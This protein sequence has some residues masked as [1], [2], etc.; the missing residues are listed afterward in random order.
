MVKIIGQ[1]Q[2]FGSPGIEPRWTHNQQEDGG[3]AQNTGWTRLAI[4]I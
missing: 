1:V 3:F 4:I 2:A